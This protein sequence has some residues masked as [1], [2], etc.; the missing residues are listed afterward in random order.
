MNFRRRFDFF[1]NALL[2]FSLLCLTCC[3]S[4]K[5]V[6]RSQKFTYHTNSSTLQTWSPTDYTMGSEGSV[7]ELT[8]MPLYDFAM[9]KDQDGYDIVAEMADGEPVD[10]TLEYAG[11]ELYGIPSD[12]TEGWAWKVNLNKNAV[13][14][15][16]EK[17][18]SSAYEYSL[19]QFLNP[20]MKNFRAN[21]FCAG[22][23]DI[24]NAQEYY[25]GEISW[26]KVGFVK[27]DD[28]S[29]TLILTKQITPFMFYY[30]S[31]S[32][33]LLKKDL[34]ESNKKQTGDI[35]KSAYCTSVQTSAS[36]GPLKVVEYQADKYIHLEKNESWYGWTDG[37]HKGQ[38][39]T[40][41]YDI[42]FISDMETLTNLFLQGKQDVL[43]L[44]AIR[45]QRF[46]SSEY[47]VD[48]PASYTWKFSFNI[49]K[50]ALKAEESPGINH[51]ILSY[52]D[53]RHGISLAL[54][55]QKYVD[56]ITIGSDAGFGLIN[57]MY[58]AVPEENLCYRDTESAKKILCDFY[59][60]N[61]VE[62][63]TG[64]NKEEASKYFQKAYDKAV[65]NGDLKP[66]DKIQIDYH[67]YSESDVN[68]RSVAFLQ[69]ALDE[70][71]KGTSLEGKIKIN[72]VID[73]KYYS[74]M[75]SGKVDVAMTGWGGGAYD[76][77]GILWCYC[78][79]AA[80][81]E[82][83][84]NPKE[85]KVVIEIEGQKMER[86]FYEW[87]MA[88]CNGEY[89]MAS[90]DI[91]NHILASVEKALL[92]IYNMIPLRYL[93][94]ASLNS[95][96]IVDGSEQFINPLVGFGGLRFMTY[97]MDDE[98]WD[99]YCKENNYRLEY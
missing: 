47:R 21:T 96:R 62:D 71:A 26:D 15:D 51:S 33:I 28:Y 57:Y 12:A 73:E 98:E 77:Y 93:N 42:Q 2:L 16:G 22:T 6:S 65:E 43:A 9:N 18:D 30:S 17:I 80:L 44:D 95:Q 37:R 5:E 61:S 8:V 52:V 25:D 56:T 54:D 4:K 70:A 86:T 90:Y 7:L 59:G 36:Y 85:E 74:N 92:E 82:Y 91:K 64:Y 13:W 87:Y 89:S 29:F 23:M 55:R 79:P 81:N 35:E 45:M 68:K 31:A 99:A 53:F 19:Q 49:D 97:T 20:K 67:I 40:T 76:P 48:S 14:D 46:G 10:V 69:E 88:L 32:I 41:G 83:G 39:Q 38:F 75:Q 66:S 78:D 1:K 34:Y 60:M 63:I 94:S 84:F 24:V 50:K 3:S 11:N 27:N 72:S 58:I